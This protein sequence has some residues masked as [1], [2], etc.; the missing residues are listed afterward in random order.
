MVSTARDGV[1][2]LRPRSALVSTLATSTLK[3]RPLLGVIV[4]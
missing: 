4:S 2:Q 1:T 3:Q